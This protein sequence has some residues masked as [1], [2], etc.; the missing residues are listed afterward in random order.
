MGKGTP[1]TEATGVGGFV[2][3]VTGDDGVGMKC[4]VIRKVQEGAWG[5]L[6]RN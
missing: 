4:L 2:R 1:Q 6:G 3:P 5:H